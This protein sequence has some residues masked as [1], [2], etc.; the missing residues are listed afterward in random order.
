MA[1]D[2]QLLRQGGD[3]VFRTLREESVHKRDHRSDGG[4][5]EP[6]RVKYA[7][8]QCTGFYLLHTAPLPATDA[9]EGFETR[10]KKKTTCLAASKLRN[11]RGPKNPKVVNMGSVQ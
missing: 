5:S 10:D 3:V 6:Q 8:G 4:L 9:G 11:G 1:S 7:A 2:L